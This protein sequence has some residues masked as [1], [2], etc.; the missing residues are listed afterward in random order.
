M[1]KSVEIEIKN[2]IG[3]LILKREPANAINRQFVG[4]ILRNF[5]ELSND[6]RCN[7]IVISSGLPKFFAA[8]ADIDMILKFSK[9]ESADTTRFFSERL[10]QNCK[11]KKTYD[12]C[13]KWIC[14]WRR[15]RTHF[16]LRL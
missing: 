5:D 2:G 16:M 8:G 9:A 1:D 13:D 11:F 7:V 3:H 4:E 14:T 10:Q 15:M 6:N 12:C